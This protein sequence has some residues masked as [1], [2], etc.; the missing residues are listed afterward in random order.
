MKNHPDKD[1]GG[2]KQRT[3]APGQFLNQQSQPNYSQH[4]HG[5]F[6]PVFQ[7]FAEARRVHSRAPEF[8]V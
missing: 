2:F 4:E 3:Q 7:F 8:R 6:K 5:R 1:A